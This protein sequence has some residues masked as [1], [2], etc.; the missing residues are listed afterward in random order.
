[1]S[2]KQRVVFNSK[3][4]QKY[5]TELV[6]VPVELDEV[7]FKRLIMRFE[8]DKRTGKTQSKNL[9]DFASKLLIDYVNN[10]KKGEADVKI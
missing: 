10:I 7:T 1:M 3:I 5:T 4:P 2:N 9:E 6:E 8:E